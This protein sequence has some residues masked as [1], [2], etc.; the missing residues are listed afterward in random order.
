MSE[1]IFRVPSFL[2]NVEVRAAPI[3]A[4]HFRR[5]PDLHLLACLQ[6]IHLHGLQNCS[7]ERAAERLLKNR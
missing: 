2:Y 5:L 1:E 3:C 7:H 4:G 6:I